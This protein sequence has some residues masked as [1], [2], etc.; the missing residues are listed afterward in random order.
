MPV[1]AAWGWSRA[2][3][4]AIEARGTRVLAP[5][6]DVGDAAALGVALEAARAELPPLR[7]VFHAAMVLDDGPFAELSPERFAAVGH[8]KVRGGWN[9]HLATERDPLDHFLLFSSIAAVLGTPGQAN[10]AAANAFL[11]GLAHARRRAGLP[12][13]AVDLGIVDGA[14]VVARASE[15]TR[16]R[17]LGRGIEAFSV[18]RALEVLAELLR[19][20]PVERVAAA[21]DWTAL[22]LPPEGRETCFSALARGQVRSAEGRSLL[23]ELQA[24]PAAKRA[25]RIV[26]WVGEFLAQISGQDASDIDAGASLSRLGI[27]SLMAN[28]LLLWLQTS[29]KVEIPLV[30]LMQ[31]PTVRE[32]AEDIAQR[33]LLGASPAPAPDDT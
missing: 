26:A 24:T 9:L 2:R 6:C 17:I 7:G 8:P 23:E 15:E 28:Q 30:R 14:G 18:E 1:A 13:T 29:F 31:G 5:P 21:I 11:D 22:L 20:E 32:L 4:S 19:V 10:Y 16:A 12:A 27:D 33:A 3:V 25:E